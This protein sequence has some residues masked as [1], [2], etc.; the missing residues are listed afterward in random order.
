MTKA[1]VLLGGVGF[2]G[3]K[4]ATHDEALKKGLLVPKIQDWGSER[5]LVEQFVEMVKNSGK[6][7]VLLCHEKTLISED[8]GATTDVL[9]LLT[10]KGVQAVSLK[11]D[12]M[13]YLKPRRKGTEFVH[14][15]KTEADAIHMVGSRYGLP[16][17]TP[18]EYADVLAGLTQIHHSK[19]Q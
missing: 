10:G 14:E 4:S 16:D 13:Y 19:E 8:T 5:S 11:F 12:E 2:K 3:A 17:G 7:F 18:W 15:L 1:I 9:P 6:H